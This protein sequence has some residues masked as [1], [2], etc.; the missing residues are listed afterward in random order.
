MAPTKKIK[1]NGTRLRFE[2]S[3]F[4]AADNLRKKMSAGEFKHVVL[5]LIFLK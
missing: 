3:P 5:G 1:P 4:Q 2:A